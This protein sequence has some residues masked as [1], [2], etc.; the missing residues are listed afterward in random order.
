MGVRRWNDLAAPAVK[1]PAVRDQTSDEHR[2]VTAAASAARVVVNDGEPGSPSRIAELT[3]REALV[4][5]I[6]GLPPRGLVTVERIE[7]PAAFAM[8]CPFDGGGFLVRY[9]DDRAHGR[10][11]TVRATSSDAAKALRDWAVYAEGWEFGFHPAHK[12]PVPD[13]IPIAHEPD[14]RTDLIG[15]WDEGLFFAGYW[16]VTY[17]HQFDHDGNHVRSRIAIAEQ[18]LGTA[19]VTA[20]MT[21]L[22]DIVDELPGRRFGDIAVRL[23]SVEHGGKK[24]G[25]F[26]ETADHLI[27]H[28]EMRP[29]LLGFAPPWDGLYDT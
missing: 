26:D 23:F 19:D 4:D 8:A 12:T 17:L 25:L 21:R 29:D 7:D 11:S 20:R 14:Y 27:P 6:A 5:L 18:Q 9:E 10:A 24:W 22:R 1:E 16:G 15:S 3:T 13:R 28:V 2:E